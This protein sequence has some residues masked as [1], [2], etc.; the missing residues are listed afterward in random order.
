MQ[1]NLLIIDTGIFG[2]I[3]WKAT[4]MKTDQQK[5]YKMKHR[6]KRKIQGQVSKKQTF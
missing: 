4:Y 3:W 2:S 5:L 6:E 1:F